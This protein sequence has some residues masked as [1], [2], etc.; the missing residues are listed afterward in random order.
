[1]N[2]FEIDPDLPFVA[3][4]V[5][6]RWVYHDDG[7]CSSIKGSGV[8]LDYQVDEDADDFVKRAKQ[9]L[10]SMPYA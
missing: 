8:M 10:L 7:W 4:A 3:S 9:I 6:T 1:M 5:Y 2:R